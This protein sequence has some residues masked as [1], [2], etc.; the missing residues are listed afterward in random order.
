MALLAWVEWICNI[1]YSIKSRK[2]GAR[3]VASSSC[4]FIK[5]P[6]GLSA[7]GPLFVNTI[8]L[9]SPQNFVIIAAKTLPAFHEIVYNPVIDGKQPVGQ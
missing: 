3:G 1:N 6:F 8:A 2:Q 9:P 5:V 4:K 7:T